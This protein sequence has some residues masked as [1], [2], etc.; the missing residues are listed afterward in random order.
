MKKLALKL[1]TL[2][3]QSFETQA[4]REGRGTVAGHAAPQPFDSWDCTEDPSCGLW[5][6]PTQDQSPTGPCAC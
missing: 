2:E 4:V 6:P 1:E 5:C 3:V